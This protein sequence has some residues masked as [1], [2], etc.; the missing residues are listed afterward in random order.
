MTTNDRYLNALQRRKAAIE[1]RDDLLKFA[2]FM[3]P[4]ADFPEDVSKSQYI[5]ARHHRAIAAALEQV[6]VGLIPR[7]IINVPPR[8]GKSQ[9]SSRMFPAW[10]IGR[11]PE[12]SIILATYSDKLSWDFGREVR[13]II[14]DSLYGQVFPGV[15]LNTASVDR[16]E[17]SDSG[18]VFFVGRGS[19][20]TGRG[21]IGL[22]I[23]DPI[24]DR[25]EADSLVTRKKLWEWFNQVAKTRLLS[26]IGWIVLIQCLTGDT[27]ISMADGSL[28][29]LDEVTPGDQVI[30]WDGQKSVSSKVTAVIDNGL[31]QTYLLKTNRTE[32][33][34][35]ARHPFLVLSA[36]GLKW[37]RMRD[38]RSGMRII[39]HGMGPTKAFSAP[40][41]GATNRP[42]AEACVT[43]ITANRSGLPGR[44]P[45]PMLQ[46]GDWSSAV[47]GATASLL[48]ILTGCLPNRAV[49]APFVGLMEA[50][51]GPS[52]GSPISFPTIITRQG[53]F[54]AS[55]ATTATGSPDELEIPKSWNAPSTTS[56]IDTDTVV[57]I[58]P[59]RLE[60]VFDLSVENTY[61]FIANG[62]W[63]HN[64]RW[65]EDDLVGRL[66]DP[67]NP[68]YSASEGR[69]WK[70]IDLPALAV[71][72]ADP[73]GRKQGEALWPQRFPVSYLEDMRSAD[74]R[75]FQ[76]LYQGSPTPEKGNFFIADCIKTYNR[77]ELPEGLRFYAA[78][79]HAVSTAQDRDKTCGLIVGVDREFNLWLSEDIIWGHYSTDVVVEKM[80]DLM[81]KYKPL[82][83]WAER[84]H[85]SKSI[86]PFLRKRMVERSVYTA[87]FEVTPVHDK[88]AR[89]QSIM[90]RMAMGK[91][92]FPSF[93]PWWMEARHEMLQFPFG[94][95][96]D[97][98]DALAWIG[99][100][101]GIHTTAQAIA[102]KKPETQIGTLAWVK[103]DSLKKRR[104]QNSAEKQGW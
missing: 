63:T 31:D 82:Y 25:V 84:G 92:Y 26:S 61:N 83:W 16:I 5:V 50:L 18:K 103:A 4:D 15:S 38:L 35:N 33:R 80:V 66:T 41:R 87:L 100:G 40:S 81:A 95:R 32:V 102:K 88:K 49:F 55:Y 27:Q 64:T 6:E 2:R 48:R 76:A 3:M 10:F 19:A 62:L 1:A 98:I 68:D 36:E 30:S 29:R 22:L 58:M 67:Q 97:F 46:S 47:S 77:S 34:A 51:E 57:S 86:G 70:I 85:I 8:H 96:D 53:S 74:P 93:A 7:L 45:L 37:V 65:H 42:N 23:D 59:Y 44:D 56:G 54:A 73:L 39:R 24:K 99:L 20:I 11:H 43:N 13:E 28:K 72:N 91:V 78:S 90:A 9:L 21:S 17:T 75:G 69:K 52:I 12:E 101:L 79:D 14:E 104:E 94:V 89:A 71:S 60:K